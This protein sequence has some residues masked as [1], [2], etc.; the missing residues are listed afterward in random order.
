VGSTE[1]LKR[2]WLNE[3]VDEKTREGVMNQTSVFYLLAK[4]LVCLLGFM[5]RGCWFE[6][7]C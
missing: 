3:K 7:N 2:S 1:K 4:E 5:A 6:P